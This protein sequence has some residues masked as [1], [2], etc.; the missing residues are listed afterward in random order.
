MGFKN[1]FFSSATSSGG[2]VAIFIDTNRATR[3]VLVLGGN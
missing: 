2:H 1:L 3:E